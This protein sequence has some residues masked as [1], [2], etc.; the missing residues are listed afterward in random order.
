[1]TAALREL[2]EREATAYDAAYDDPGRRGRLV[3]AR[4][5]T[6]ARLLGEGPGEALDAGMGGGRLCA[7]LDRRGWT[8]SGTDASEAMVAL[9]RARLPHRR[10][11]LLVAPIEALPFPDA[12]FDAV[13]ALGVLE[14]ASDVACALRELARLLRPGGRAVVS[15]PGFGALPVRARR[16]LVYPVLCLGKR[17]L[18]V[19]RAVPPPPRHPLR[20]PAFLELVRAAGLAVAR[21]ERL[22]G[23]GRRRGPVLAVQIVVSAGK[24]RA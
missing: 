4:L 11:A 7:E 23:D 2:W 13:S 8:V 19:G 20:E 5:E 24:E 6:A 1:V 22:G 16:R 9:A 15:F 14:Y 12:S 18:P 10:D 17:L 21:V 3:R